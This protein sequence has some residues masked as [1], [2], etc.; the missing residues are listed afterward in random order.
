MTTETLNMIFRGANFI[1]TQYPMDLIL[2][3]KTCL[4]VDEKFIFYF[5]IMPPYKN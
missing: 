1:K 5:L 4:I 3:A 2:T